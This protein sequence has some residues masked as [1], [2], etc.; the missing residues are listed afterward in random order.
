VNPNR[1]T[2]VVALGGHAISP[3]GEVDTIPNQF[4]HTRESLIAVLHLIHEGYELVI[5]HGNA[6]QVGNALLRTEL[7]ADRA[8]VLPLGICVAD[9]EGGMGYMIQQSIQNLLKKSGIIKDVVTVITQVIVDRNDPEVT[10]P[11]KFIGQLY[12]KELARRLAK[13][14]EWEIRQTSQG[15][16]Q[17]VIPSPQPRSIV[18]SE[19][20]K[21]LVQAGKIV[22]AAGGGGIPVYYK[23]TGDLEGFDAV[24]DKDLA[25]AILAHE[26][27]ASEF[28]IL[29]DVDGVALNYGQQDE[30]WLTKM[31]VNE[32]R[33]YYKQHHFPSGSMGPKIKA[34]ISFLEKGGNVVLITSI[35]NIRKTLK[36][37]AGTIIQ[38]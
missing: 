27:G 37:K 11:T 5:T 23:K 35:N 6:P 16:W 13:R 31:T 21:E 32:A 25:S 19:S 33:Y 4:R 26:I 8:P 29:T 12:D 9:I 36:G 17:R 15:D 14:F 10:H 28:I 38:K 1:K 2:A 22:I 3:R 34:A 30:K 20:I 18:E 24:V 7:T